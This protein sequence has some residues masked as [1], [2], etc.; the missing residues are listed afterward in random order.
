MSDQT[1]AMIQTL[2]GLG[3]DTDGGNQVQEVKLIDDI[4]AD[5]NYKGTFD[6]QNDDHV[7]KLNQQLISYISRAGKV[8]E[9]EAAKKA[10]EWLMKLTNGV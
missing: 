4:P 5:S 7:H 3:D 10:G 6:I 1:W 8:S 2:Q 9:A